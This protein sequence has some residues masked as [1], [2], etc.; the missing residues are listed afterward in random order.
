MKTNDI[1][2]LVFQAIFAG[3][4]KSKKKARAQIYQKAQVN[5]ILPASLHHFYQ[6]FGR[7][8]VKGFTVPAFNIRTLTY[9]TAAL[10]FHLA[11]KKN[12]GAFVF[13]IA[14]SEIGYTQQR[15]EEYTTA[16]L[17]GAIK[18]GWAGLVFLQGDHYQFKASVYQE[19][20]QEEIQK[21]KDLIKES[22]A[23]H[24]YNIDIDASTLVDLNKKS[25]DDQQV[26]NYRMTVL[27][28]EYIRSLQPNG[29]I[30]SIG[31]EIGHI[32]GINST[33]A[34]FTAFMEGY[35]KALAGKNLAGISKVSVQTGTSHGGIPLADGTIADVKLDFSV[36]KTI[37]EAA[38]L[39]Y[40]LGGPVQ[41]GAST[42]PAELFDQFPKNGTLEIHLATGFQNLVYDRLPPLLKNEIYQW[43][44]N[45]CQ[46]EWKKDMTEEQFLY[47]T[48][49]KALG[50][51][52][53][54]IWRLFPK[55]KQPIMQAL[56]KQFSFLFEKLKVYNTQS[57]INRYVQ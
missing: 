11:K 34:D 36:L 3:D 41:H 33:V 27:L 10:I 16:V 32:G 20:P 4:E 29:V 54:K 12:V 31:G 43:L 14:R 22:I 6:A 49:K 18:A 9:D 1:D 13:E 2:N 7:Q 52:K 5:G 17:A 55:E 46:D 40:H 42:L 30:V 8:Q 53:E 48:R 47:K 35:K 21:L 38:R 56:E 23:A 57:I 26:D 39:N 44:K 25:L 50:P 19:N 45:N 37:S 51:F 15:P 24:F 28:T